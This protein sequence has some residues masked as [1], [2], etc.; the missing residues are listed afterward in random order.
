M[1]TH[2][3]VIS[4]GADGPVKI[5]ISNSPHGRLSGFQTSSPV[6]LTLVHSFAMP[7]REIALQI[8]GMFHDTQKHRRVRGEWFD[9]KPM[10]A[11]YLLAMGIEISLR[12]NCHDFDE[13]MLNACFQKCGVHAAFEMGRSD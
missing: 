9:L 4:A 3:Y 7:N 1:D 5:G 8:E 13:Q 2:V 12:H 11:V 6:S 10:D